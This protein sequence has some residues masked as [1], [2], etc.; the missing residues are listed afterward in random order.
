MKDRV[1]LVGIG[2][3]IAVLMSNSWLAERALVQIADSTEKVSAT[4]QTLC[5][6]SLTTW[7]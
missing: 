3:G 1:T 7:C 6:K 5:G 4:S 2:I